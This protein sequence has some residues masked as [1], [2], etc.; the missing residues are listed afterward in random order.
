M[1]RGI[2]LQM[3]KLIDIERR[4]HAAAVK[5]AAI[6]TQVKYLET[7]DAKQAKRRLG[8]IGKLQ[9]ELNDYLN[10]EF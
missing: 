5:R 4:M 7:D 8:Y 2:G 9:R 6:A 10:E 1:R 3:T